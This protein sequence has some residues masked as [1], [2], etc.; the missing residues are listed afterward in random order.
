MYQHTTDSKNFKNL[1]HLKVYAFLPPLTMRQFPEKFGM[2]H[3]PRQFWIL[4]QLFVK[5]RLLN[6]IDKFLTLFDQPEHKAKTTK[7][8][9]DKSALQN[10]NPNVYLGIPS[11][12]RNSC[13][14]ANPRCIMR[15]HQHKLKGQK[16]HTSRSNGIWPLTRRKR[17]GRFNWNP[18]EVP[19]IEGWSERRR[20]TRRITKD[21][22]LYPP[23]IMLSF[24]TLP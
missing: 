14:W 12:L 11:S 16:I 9:N 20:R 3:D 19:F 5:I 22:T 21:R 15:N 24:P 7:P 4:L 13:D 17:Q 1:R 2:Q 10:K 6:T 23:G 18:R 8:P